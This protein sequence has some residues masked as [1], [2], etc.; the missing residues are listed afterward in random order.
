MKNEL[1]SWEIQVACEI[2]HYKDISEVPTSDSN[3]PYTIA[4]DIAGW[5]LRY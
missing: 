3:T 4:E 5:M 2:M 1:P